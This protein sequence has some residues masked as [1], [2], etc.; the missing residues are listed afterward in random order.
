MSE[1]TKYLQHLINSLPGVADRILDKTAELA[2][3]RAKATTLFKDNTGGLRK[4]IGIQKNGK[5]ARTVIA[6]KFYAFYVEEGNNQK[7]PYIYPKRA[8]ALHFFINGQEIFA[9]RVRSHGPLPFLRVSRDFTEKLANA[10][11]EKEL[12]KW[13]G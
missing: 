6:D 13:I 7:G 9:K 2:Q 12:K 4:A 1:I 5:M 10:I 11:A 8:K 3:K